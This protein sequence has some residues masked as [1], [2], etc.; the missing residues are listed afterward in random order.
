MEDGEPGARE[1]ILRAVLGLLED[2]GGD[3][4]TTRR[5]GAI[6]HVPAPTIY[7]LFGDKQGLIDA[8]VE[9]G[10]DDWIDAKAA[11]PRAE[12][13]VE[14]LRAGWDDAVAFALRHPALYRI[15]QTRRPASLAVGHALLAGKVHRAALAGRLRVQEAE[16]LG[17]LQAASRGVVLE[18]L[19]APAEHR[20][21]RASELMR[22]AVIARITAVDQEPSEQR[23]DTGS[24]AVMLAA[25]AS[26]APG[27]TDAERLLLV[28]WL[29]R[30]AA[31]GRASRHGA[32]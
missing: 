4:V 23:D 18:L 3:A 12:D 6:A 26:S 30:L 16:A 31:A 2:E 29:N 20:I 27:F 21:P 8:A 22:D 19:D 9:R 11:L 24:A 17:L 7:R 28:E 10:Y 13:A 25:A 32:E 14:A 1:R 15:A 5:V